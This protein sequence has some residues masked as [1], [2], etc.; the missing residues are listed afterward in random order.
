VSVCM[1]RG[2]PPEVFVEAI[3]RHTALLLH[4]FRHIERLGVRL[5]NTQ[6]THT[7]TVDM[8]SDGDTREV[9]KV[10][11]HC[12]WCLVGTNRQSVR[13][14]DVCTARDVSA[15]FCV[16]MYRCAARCDDTDGRQHCCEG[17]P[18]HDDTRKRVTTATECGSLCTVN[19]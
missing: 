16:A 18:T 5:T 7:C 6:R 12:G 14:S 10:S 3:P 9:E 15:A 2:C 4:P 19:W 8:L 13:Y 11:S 1:W 17:Q